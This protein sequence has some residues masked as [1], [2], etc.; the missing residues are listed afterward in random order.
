MSDMTG[1]LTPELLAKIEEAET[2]ICTFSYQRP[3]DVVR[4]KALVRLG[5]GG[6]VRGVVQVVKKDG[7]ENNLHYHTTADSLWFVLKGRVRF[8]GVGDKFLGEF[9]QHEGIITPAYSRYWFENAGDE[10]LELLQCGAL[11][12]EDQQ[13]TGRTDIDPAENM[14][15]GQKHYKAQTQKGEPVAS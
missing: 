7:G 13:N 8:Y 6:H 11:A 15:T 1:T 9:G 12:T 3:S 14:L 10:D 5:R 2:K 4:S